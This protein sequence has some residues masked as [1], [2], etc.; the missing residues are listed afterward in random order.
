[1][2]QFKRV[3]YLF[4][5]FEILSWKMICLDEQVIRK[6][7][8]RNFKKIFQI[9]KIVEFKIYSNKREIEVL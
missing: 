2:R 9:I 1:M 6:L 5:D 8:L 7:K 3:I 4:G